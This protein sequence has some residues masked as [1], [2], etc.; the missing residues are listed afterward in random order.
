MDNYINSWRLLAFQILARTN[1]F[2]KTATEMGLTQSAISHAIAGLEKGLGV[3]L[4]NR[5][6]RTVTLTDEGTALLAYADRIFQEMGQ[7]K[8]HMAK[9]AKL[10]KK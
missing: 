8:Q 1:S 6:G 10:Q 2:T 9:M 7:A 5:L 4:F 3:R